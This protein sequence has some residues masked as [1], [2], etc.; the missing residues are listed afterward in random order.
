VW[1]EGVEKMNASMLFIGK[2]KE[3]KPLR[4]PRPTRVNNIKI[5]VGE[6]IWGGINWSGSRY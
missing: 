1:L 2:P 5:N 3:G 4:R 6:I